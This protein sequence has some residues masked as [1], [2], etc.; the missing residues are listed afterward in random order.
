MTLSDLN[1]FIIRKLSA[2]IG[3]REASA[4]ARL[5]LEDVLNVSQVKLLTHGDRL[6]EPETEALFYK[7]IERILSGEPPQYI[8]GKA[9][10]MGMDFKV[11]RDTLIPRPETAELVDIVVDYAKKRHGLKIL[12]V[13]TGSGCIAIA[14]ARALPFAEIT[15]IDI[16]EAAL[17][18]ARENAKNLNVIIDFFQEDILNTRQLPLDFNIVVSNPPY[19][20]EKEKESMDI[21]VKE[22]EPSSALFVPDNDPLKFYRAII[23]VTKVMDSNPSLFFEIN[24]Y[25]AK[26][27]SEIL[28]N[29]GYDVQILR[30]SISR[31]RFISASH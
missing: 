10:F 28:S 17:E 23:K 16:S 12:D 5:L 19:I 29:A 15:A 2:D 21:R 31:Q 25:Y 6:I 20:T 14:L 4:T 9:R 24:P 7:I 22:F 30:D 26:E 27:L 18:V 3:Q 1:T 8:I 13:G 11:T